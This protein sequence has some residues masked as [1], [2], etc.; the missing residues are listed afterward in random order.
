L[1]KKCLRNVYNIT[2]L[3]KDIMIIMG[4]KKNRGIYL[5]LVFC[6]CA[7]IWLY[8]NQSSESLVSLG[9]IF[10]IFCLVYFKQIPKATQIKSEDPYR[11]SYEVK[12]FHNDFSKIGSGY[13]MRKDQRVPCCGGVVEGDTSCFH[14]NCG[15]KKND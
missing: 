5:L 13:P 4:M 14:K 2:H 12:E 8:F 7:G 3:F 10:F 11:V 9:L 15:D 6:L 1:D